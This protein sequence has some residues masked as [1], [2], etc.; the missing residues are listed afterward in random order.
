MF[1]K[2][3]NIL[4]TNYTIKESRQEEDPL[5]E[6]NDAYVDKTTKS[7]VVLTGYETTL[8]NPEWYS[9]KLLRHEIVHAFLYESGLHECSNVNTMQSEIVVD[10]IANQGPKIYKAWEEAG[11]V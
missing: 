5:L 1:S 10:W 9:K 7:I 6:N 4:G 11:A 3:V 2:K 8:H